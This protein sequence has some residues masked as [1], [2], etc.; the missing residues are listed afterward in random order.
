MTNYDF[1][2][3]TKKESHLFGKIKMGM[4]FILCIATA[5][6]VG[7]QLVFATSLAT[8]GAKLAQ[9]EAEIKRMEAQNTSLRA[10]IAQESALNNLVKKAPQMGF[11]EEK[12]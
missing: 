10:R 8:D 6:I 7:V 11:L 3:E 1:K 5:L 2:L 4:I 12:K 9:I